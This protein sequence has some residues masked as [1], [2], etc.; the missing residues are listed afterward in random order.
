MA[1]ALLGWTKAKDLAGEANE[2]RKRWAID[3]RFEA[4]VWVA[5]VNESQIEKIFPKLARLR[6]CLTGPEGAAMD[7]RMAC[8][9]NF[10]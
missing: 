9:E 8:S 2:C 7:K 5:S 1:M 3:Y 10:L 6:I 4:T